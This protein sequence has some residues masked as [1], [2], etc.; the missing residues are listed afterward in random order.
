MID[1]RGDRVAAVTGF[2]APWVYARFGEIP[3]LMTPEF[4]RRFGL[5]DEVRD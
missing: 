4:F 2:I 3:G 1:L 5:P